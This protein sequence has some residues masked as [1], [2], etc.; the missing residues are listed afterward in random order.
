MIL[1]A[2]RGLMT[3]P[4]KDLENHPDQINFALL[5]NYNVEIDLWYSNG[6]LY[7]GHDQPQYPTTYD[8]VTQ[9]GLWLHCKNLEALDYLHNLHYK[10]HYFWHENDAVTL[11]SRGVVIT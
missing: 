6:E 10:T 5:K 2:H 8:F 4:D 7:L 9:K 1:I 11:T 3:G